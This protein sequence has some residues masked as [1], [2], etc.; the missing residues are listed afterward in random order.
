MSIEIAE[1]EKTYNFYKLLNYIQ[2]IEGAFG[3]LDYYQNKM[4]LYIFI[5]NN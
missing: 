4:N 1:L 2:Y 5:G 3:L